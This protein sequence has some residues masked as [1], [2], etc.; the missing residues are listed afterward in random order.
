MLTL[1]FDGLYQA[2]TEHP[3]RGSQA[4]VM[5]YGWLIERDGVMIARG[6]GGY[7]RAMEATSNIAE[8]L[9]L[10][11]GLSALI[12]L[13]CEDESIQVIGDARSVIDQMQ[14]VVAVHS[15]STRRLYRRARRLAGRF[16]RL[17]WRWAPRRLNRRADLLSR[18]AMRQIYAHPGRYRAALEALGADSGA[19]KEHHRLHSLLDLRIYQP[20]GM[21]E[22]LI[23]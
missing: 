18:K 14:G 20:A 16:H 21:P 11:E 12:D 4:G 2:L 17:I 9:A 6:H 23:S 5:C 8:Y 13:G 3:P 19:L 1:C 15:A 7:V 10:I 22:M